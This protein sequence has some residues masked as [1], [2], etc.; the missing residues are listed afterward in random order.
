MTISA[1]GTPPC[2]LVINYPLGRGLGVGAEEHF[3]GGMY[4]KS[5]ARSAPRK[6]PEV[7]L[8]FIVKIQKRR[9]KRAGDFRGILHKIKIK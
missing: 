9:A 8:V 3:P 1:G 7:L 6:D 2:L 5:G 4:Q